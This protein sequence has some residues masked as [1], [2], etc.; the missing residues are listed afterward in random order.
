MNPVS[1][2]GYAWPFGPRVIAATKEL[3]DEFPFNLDMNS[4]K[5]LGVGKRFTS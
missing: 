4:G 2:N 3:P 1:L 5:P